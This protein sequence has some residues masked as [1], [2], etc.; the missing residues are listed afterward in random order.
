MVYVGL[1]LRRPRA[2][3]F[4][5][6]AMC[7]NTCFAFFL[8]KLTWTFF[9]GMGCG[10]WPELVLRLLQE[11]RSSSSCRL[12]QLVKGTMPVHR[13]RALLDCPYSFKQ[14]T[15]FDRSLLKK[16]R[17]GNVDKNVAACFQISC[18]ASTAT[19]TI[20][21]TGGLAC[22]L[23]GGGRLGSET[24]VHFLMNRPPAPQ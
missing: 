9:G 13:C 12:F 3:E 23:G 19:R 10:C 17:R 22:R 8:L 24:M 15:R 11:D 6:P 20:T 21:I 16:R 18:P 14:G 7:V 4:T 1:I 5:Q 2:T